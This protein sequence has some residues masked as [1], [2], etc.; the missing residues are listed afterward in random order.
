MKIN[1]IMTRNVEAASPGQSIREAA[2]I[3]SRIDSGALLVNDKD[4]LVGRI[5][6]RDI[7]ICAVAEN[8]AHI[9]MRRLPV[10]NREKRLMG[11]MSLGNIASSRSDHTSGTLLRGVA[12]A[13]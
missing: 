8:M 9:Q 1:E 12:Q 7:A 5:T 6:N 10:F 3:M 11:V 13:H 4:H 2:I